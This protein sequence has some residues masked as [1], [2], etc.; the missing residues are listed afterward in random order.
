[1]KKP[2]LIVE[3]DAEIKSIKEELDKGYE[4]F[5]EAQEFVKKQQEASWKQLVGSQW[6]KVE[7]LLRDRNLLPEDF[8]DEKYSLGFSDG[9][10]Y[11]TSKSD[12][13]KRDIA[14]SI[15]EMIFKRD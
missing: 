14:S 3:T 12:D 11:L 15:L 7:A 10:L 5:R 9:V 1:M 6:E 13:P 8:D 4:M 2:L